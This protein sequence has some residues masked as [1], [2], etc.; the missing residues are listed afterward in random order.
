MTSGQRSRNAA[1]G[2]RVAELAAELRGAG[3]PAGV[4]DQVAGVVRT[5]GLPAVI[6]LGPGLLTDEAAGVVLLDALQD[7]A[8]RG[9]RSEE[10]ADELHAVARVQT[11][12]LD[13]LDGLRRSGSSN[14]TEA[15]A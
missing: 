3:V 5:A 10:V 14:G 1:S 11:V 4:T 15:S 12:V 6:A 9:A 8:R 2:K 13:L 7:A